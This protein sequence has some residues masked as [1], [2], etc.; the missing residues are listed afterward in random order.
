LFCPAC[1]V[2]LGTREDPNRLETIAGRLQKP[3]EELLCDG[4]RSER[5][6]FYCREKCVMAKCARGKGLD[7]CGECDEYPCGDLKAF[8]AE[9]PHRIELW[10]SQE[11]IKEVG[12]EKWYE[13]MVEHYSCPE[14]HTLNSAYDIKCRN[15]GREPSCGYVERHMREIREYLT[16]R[17]QAD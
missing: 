16:R 4:C 13:E 14:C 12:Y 7:F 2:F 1:T 10:E 17:E 9:M 15:C 11:R 3:V 8:Q 6:S 5:R